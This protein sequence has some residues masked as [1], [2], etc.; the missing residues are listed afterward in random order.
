LNNGAQMKAMP[1]MNAPMLNV[2][3][4]GPKTVRL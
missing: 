3:Q 4:N 1:P 2:A